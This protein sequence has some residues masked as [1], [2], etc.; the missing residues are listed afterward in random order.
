MYGVKNSFA[1]I[2]YQIHIK[3]GL[4]LNTKE[5]C[6]NKVRQNVW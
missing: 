1:P 6:G 5:A 4:H 3:S 2:Q